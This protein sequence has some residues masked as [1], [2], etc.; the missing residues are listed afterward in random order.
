MH[1]LSDIRQLYNPVQP[2]VKQSADH[3]TYAELMPA[4]GLQQF[5]YCYWQLRTT[6][7]LS[8]QFIYRVVA[9]G[10][11]DIYFELNNPRDSYVMGFCKKFT[12]FPLGNV[13]NYVGIRF[14][15]TMF[16]QLFKINAKELSNRFE[17]LDNVIPS[18]ADFISN[19][20]GIEQTPAQIK[21]IFDRYFL[22]LLSK[23]SFNH[24]NRL[25]DAIHL[26]LR[27]CG[28]IDIEQG[29]DTGISS[30]QLRRLFDY[31]VGDTAKTFSKVV[32]FQHILRAKPSTQ[33]LRKN[34]LFFDAGYY[35]QAHFIKE[36][37][38]FYGVTPSKAFGR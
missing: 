37:R 2:T 21:E 38:N 18:T 20:L 28:T 35:D 12:E 31:Y 8:E 17:Q 24:D 27:H 15:P 25:Y 34:K 22:D 36:F 4:P 19:H 10:C 29:L 14:L 3:V 6:Q 33:S 1:Q 9:D 32:R 16:P 26:I 7:A 5:I 11:I 13:F 23:T 30:R